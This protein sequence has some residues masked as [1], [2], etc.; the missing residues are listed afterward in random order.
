[1]TTQ[2]KIQTNGNY[3]AEIKDAAGTI[4]GSAGP[5][6]NIESGW[7]YL[8]HGQVFTFAERPATA[9]EIAKAAEEANQS[10]SENDAAKAE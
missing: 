10:T 5:G 2:V 6:A 4:V 1:M 9:E 3:V 7:I 8:P